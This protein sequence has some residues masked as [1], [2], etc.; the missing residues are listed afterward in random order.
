MAGVA[1]IAPKESQ[2]QATATSLIQLGERQRASL[3]LKT[4]TDSVYSGPDELLLEAWNCLLR[5]TGTP[6]GTCR[7]R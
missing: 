3:S 5:I 2:V 1:K 7:P 4:I 6:S